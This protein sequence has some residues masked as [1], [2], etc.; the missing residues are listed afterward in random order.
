MLQAGKQV[1]VYV[2]RSITMKLLPD[3][4]VAD[5]GSNWDLPW[6]RIGKQGELEKESRK[7]MANVALARW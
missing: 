3:A 7:M 2:T 1:S 5:I 4:R 6:I